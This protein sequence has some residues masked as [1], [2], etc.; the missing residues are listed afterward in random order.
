MENSKMD[1]K[2][3]T[4]LAKRNA[5]INYGLISGFIVFALVFIIFSI[6][7]PSFLSQ[8][9]LIRNLIMPA[10]ISAVIAMGMT[11]VMSGGG[12]DLSIANI[13]GLAGLA[14]AASS[15]QLDLP[16][17]FM[18]ISALFVGG[19]IGAINGGLVAYAG[20]SPFVVTLS[21]VYLAHGL[22]YLIALVSVSGTYLMLPRN[23]SNIGVNP[24]FQI[25]LCIV[26]FITLYIFLDHSIYGRY[27]KA[28]GVNLNAS[29]FSGIPYRFYT[30]LT[31]VICGF[32]CALT[33]IM[34]TANEGLARVGSGESYQ[35]DGFL[36]PILGKTIFGKFSVQGTIF[37]AIFIYMI[38]NG[39]FILGVTPEFVKIIKGGLLLGI[40]LVSG[41]QK[42]I[43]GEH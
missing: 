11:V 30:W 27:I 34:L 31:Y 17:P 25:G 9:N 42:V 32:C 29:H 12:I 19:L 23:V 40:I 7:A 28:V 5:H 20:I 35:I 33:G 22:Q 4:N 2:T 43:R 3:N 14:A 13:A 15:A 24:I 36:L 38:I 6:K 18:L 8:T 21:V 41:I 1:N 39:M 16:F 37:S 26:V 10:S